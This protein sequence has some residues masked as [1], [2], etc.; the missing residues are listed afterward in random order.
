M[1]NRQVVQTD[2]S[3]IYQYTLNYQFHSSTG[4]NGFVNTNY[5]MLG[6]QT[7]SIYAIHIGGNTGLNFNESTSTK[8]EGFVQVF[9]Y[10]S[11]YTSIGTKSIRMYDVADNQ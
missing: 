11:A 2:S 9:N 4:S 1:R 5:H 8:C 6:S 10:N 3:G 7:L